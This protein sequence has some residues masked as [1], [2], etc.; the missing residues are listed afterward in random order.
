ME[1]K[2]RKAT[3]C[4]FL[5]MISRLLIKV[6]YGTLQHTGIGIGLGGYAAHTYRAEPGS[7]PGRYGRL[8]NVCNVAGVTAAA[9]AVKKSIFN[10]VNGFD[11]AFQ[12]AYNDVD[13]NLKILRAGYWNLCNYNHSLIHYESKSRGEDAEGEKA[14]RFDKEKELLL[15]RWSKVIFDDPF[16]HPLLTYSNESASFAYEHEFL[17]V[18]KLVAGRVI[19]T[20]RHSLGHI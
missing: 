12:V 17:K 2:H 6:G 11:E 1:L 9:L 7:H 4:F 15:K 18:G 8:R 5:I 14:Q 13:F 10:E 3:S 16:Y 20:K 19:A